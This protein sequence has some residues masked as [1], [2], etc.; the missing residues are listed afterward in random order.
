MLER[1]HDER[2]SWNAPCSATSRRMV[3]EHARHACDDDHDAELE[4]RLALSKAQTWM[5]A[6]R[7]KRV[8][9]IVVDGGRV[10][11]CSGIRPWTWLCREEKKPMKNRSAKAWMALSDVEVLRPRII[12]R[13]R[14]LAAARSW[15]RSPFWSTDQ[16]AKSQS[17]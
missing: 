16:A 15:V 13:T 17:G 3:D 10:G 2:G 4:E 5:V 7:W 8:S 11:C 14:A 12:L 6:Q 9:R 1:G